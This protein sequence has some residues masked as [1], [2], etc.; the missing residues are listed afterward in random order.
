MEVASMPK[1]MKKQAAEV[2]APTYSKETYMLWYETMLRSRRFEERTL[3]LYSQQKIRGFCHVYIGQEAIAGAIAS[4]MRPVDPLITAYRQHAPAL[5]KGLN[6]RE[7]FAELCG[8][9]DGNV[10]GKGVANQSSR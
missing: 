4:V 8:R 7:C 10:K 6:A 9:I 2:L 1:K 5:A 3:L